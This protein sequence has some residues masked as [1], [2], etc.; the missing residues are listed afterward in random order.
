MKGGEEAVEVEGAD[1]DEVDEDDEDVEDRRRRLIACSGSSAAAQMVDEG[2]Q[3][4]FFLWHDH[5]APAT[6]AAPTRRRA[7]MTDGCSLV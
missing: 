1:D 2:Q 4:W 6:I 3:R 7:I 5:C